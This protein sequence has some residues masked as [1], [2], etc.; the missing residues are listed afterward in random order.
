[1]TSAVNSDPEDI[2]ITVLHVGAAAVQTPSKSV[3]LHQ[4]LIIY[5]MGVA[6]YQSYEC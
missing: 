2:I 5:D 3:K 4:R 1:M 6:P